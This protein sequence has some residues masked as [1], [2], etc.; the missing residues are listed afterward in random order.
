MTQSEA[1]VAKLAGSSDATVIRAKLLLSPSASVTPSSVLSFDPTAMGGR[2][3]AMAG[4]YSNYRIKSILMKFLTTGATIAV[5][6]IDDASGAEGDAPTSVSGVLEL[7]CSGS[8]FQLESIPTEVLY[9]PV[10]K[11]LWYK[12]FTGSSGSDQRLVVPAILY[13]AT[14]SDGAT[15]FQIELDCV[16]VFKGAVDTVSL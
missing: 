12:T 15:P 9:Q 5:G 1:F 8:S 13:A 6:A 14:T 10:D 3:A 11:S 4:I 7:R 2:L 16:Y